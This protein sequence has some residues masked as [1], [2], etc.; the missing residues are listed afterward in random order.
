MSTLI[1]SGPTGK[2][3]TLSLNNINLSVSV[4]GIFGVA[5][6]ATALIF[7]EFPIPINVVTDNTKLIKTFLTLL[8]SVIFSPCFYFIIFI[9]NC[10]HFSCCLLLK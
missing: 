2:V 5:A 3:F 8:K 9:C 4:T 1:P 10:K 6:S 7:F